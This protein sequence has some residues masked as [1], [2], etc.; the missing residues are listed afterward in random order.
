MKHGANQHTERGGYNYNVLKTR[1]T[2]AE[3]LTSVIARDFPDTLE[4]MK[5][6]ILSEPSNLDTIHKTIAKCPTIEVFIFSGK[7]QVLH[8]ITG[9][10]MIDSFYRKSCH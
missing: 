7:I 10:F 1:G 2:S 4:E 6:G 5:A 3:Y 9:Q 8:W